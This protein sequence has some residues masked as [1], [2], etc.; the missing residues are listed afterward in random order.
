MKI[1]VKFGSIQYKFKEDKKLDD[2]NI[3]NVVF[4]RLKKFM[5]KKQ[6]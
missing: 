4:P 5:S 1:N 3:W 2:I 6:A